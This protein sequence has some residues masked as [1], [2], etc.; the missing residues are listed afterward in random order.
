MNAGTIV[1]LCFVIMYFGVV[2]YIMWDM[3]KKRSQRTS[4]GEKG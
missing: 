3:W 1:V 2:V 4:S